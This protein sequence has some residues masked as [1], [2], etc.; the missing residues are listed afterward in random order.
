MYVVACLPL[1]DL[2]RKPMALVAA[3]RRRRRRHSFFS[4]QERHPKEKEKR[5]GNY[6]I[7]AQTQLNT[8]Q[9]GILKPFLLVGGYLACMILHPYLFNPSRQISKNKKKTKFEISQDFCIRF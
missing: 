3:C 5:V 6:W 9:K 4:L 1:T 2:K 8:H 7:V